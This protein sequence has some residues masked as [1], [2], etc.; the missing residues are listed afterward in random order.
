[1][2]ALS[3]HHLGQDQ[4]KVIQ[5]IVLC[6]LIKVEL[7]DLYAFDFFGV[8]NIFCLNLFNFM[9]QIII[10]FKFYLS[11]ISCSQEQVRRI[12][13]E[14]RRLN[15]VVDDLVDVLFGLVLLPLIL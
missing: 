15:V 11:I 8:Q 3:Q 7:N 1:M 12:S 4:E 6:Q 10:I 13:Q 9:N 5:E 14:K 2:T